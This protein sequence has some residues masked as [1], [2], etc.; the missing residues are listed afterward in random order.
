MPA[1]EPPTIII[2]LVMEFLLFAFVVAVRSPPDAVVPP[3]G[4]VETNCSDGC[5][6]IVGRGILL[7]WQVLSRIDFGGSRGED[8]CVTRNKSTRKTIERIK[9]TIWLSD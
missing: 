8:D 6:H 1:K 9:A 2:V 3:S 4:V 7:C 5:S